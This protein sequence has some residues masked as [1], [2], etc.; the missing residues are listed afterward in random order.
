MQE[1][2]PPR[3]TCSHEACRARARR[4]CPARLP[5]VPAT[6]STQ[7]APA[8]SPP[9]SPASR[10]LPDGVPPAVLRPERPLPSADGWPGSEAFARTSGTGRLDRGSLLWTD[11][12]Y[13]DRGTTAPAAGG[14]AG[15]LSE[16]GTP[17][18]GGYTY[19]SPSAK[20][21]AAD[22]F[23]AGVHLDRSAS[24]WRVDWTTFADPSLPLAVWTMDTDDSTATG[25]SDWPAAAGVSS[26]GVERSLV[27]SAKGAQL[28]DGA[29]TV[30]ARPT[31]T[32]DTAARSFVVRISR[33]VLPVAGTWS[34]RLAAGVADP[35]GTSM[36]R[37][38]GALP[39]QPSVYQ[40]S[41]RTLAQEPPLY[42][43]WNDGAQVAALA[44]GDVSDFAVDVVWADLAARRS[45]PEASPKG[46]SP[47]W[48][49]SSVEPGQGQLTGADTLR[50]GQPNYL[51]RVQ[52][53]AVYVPA[54]YDGKRPTSLTFLLHSFTQN[55][56]QYASTTP[57]F[58]RLAC[59]ERD[60]ICVTTLGRGPDGEYE[61]LA[62]LDVWEVWGRVAAGF[63]L[64]SERT[65]VAGYSMGGFGTTKLATQHPD[66]FA[67]AVTLAG[68]L[69]DYPQLENLRELPYYLAGGAADELVPF[70]DQLAT[71]ELLDGFGYRYRWLTHAT[72]HVA[73]ELQDGFADA[74]SWMG[75]SVRAR[76]PGR[77]T[78]TWDK[79]QEQPALGIGVTGA[80]WLRSLSART[81][82]ARVE[83]S[84]GGLFLADPT[85]LTAPG[86]VAPGDTAGPAVVR[87]LTWGP[88]PSRVRSR[89]LVLSLTGVRSVTVDLAGAGLD[90]GGAVRLTT[91]ADAPTTVVL[92][93][94]RSTRTVTVPTG[95][96]TR[97]LRPARRDLPAVTCPP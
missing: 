22:V 61:G 64:D 31:V 97:T 88:G 74:A 53:Y 92:V 67:K 55:H 65:V 39:G 9:A 11:F 1:A 79:R 21:N 86:I 29:G 15:S 87:E 33:T 16:V 77:I 19:T 48:Y 80:Y 84:S 24:Y 37:P 52:P 70:T 62:E 83:A 93:G 23:R 45:T 66:L 72:D 42:Q 34:V 58:S 10:G 26:P 82:A 43:F 14:P 95:T 32:V 25:A 12:L 54:A 38:G 90:R 6:G 96:S 8:A 89:D 47:R 71:A 56:N 2:G 40:A 50:D 13:D 7:A 4:R 30:L 68:S 73:Y 60:S 17:S 94:P 78:F 51:D 5:R 28:L 91:T 20:G 36:A 57:T 46:W 85:P 27:L 41:F 18:F 76:R 69:G 75:S 3:R 44:T 63:R 35:S 81:G 59:E 49:V